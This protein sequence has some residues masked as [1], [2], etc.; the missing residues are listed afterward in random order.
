MSSVVVELC[1]FFDFADVEC[2]TASVGGHV[3]GGGGWKAVLRGT[4]LS[5][6]F[7]NGE[8]GENNDA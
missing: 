3:G 6:R 5:A 1:W 8:Q 2:F 7:S 4:T